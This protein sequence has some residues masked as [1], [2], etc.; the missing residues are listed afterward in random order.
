MYRRDLNQRK[1]S[2][3]ILAGAIFAQCGIAVMPAAAAEPLRAMGRLSP[4]TGWVLA[5]NHLLWTSDA[6]HAW[7]E[8]TPPA[9][10]AREL[11]GAFFLNASN[12]W[13]L[14]SHGSGEGVELARTGNGGAEWSVA[15]F[16]LGA[17]DAAGFGGEASLDF[18]DEA[19][20]WAML[21]LTSSSNFSLGMLF[22]TDDGG[23]T[24]KRLPAPPLGDP[25]RFVSQSEGWLSSSSGSN[26][27]YVTRDGGRT[28][29]R[30]SA[31]PE[32]RRAAPPG[33]R[34]ALGEN[35][36]M[37]RADF[38]DATHGWVIAT[39]AHC[40]GFKTGCTQTQKLLSTTDGGRTFQD[41]TPALAV[42]V[43]PAST[44]TGK[45][46]GF[47]QCA[48]GSTSQMDT[49]YKDSPFKSSNV[50]I[51]GADRGCSQPGLNSSW[52]STVTGQG[53]KLIPT[54]V[55]PQAP[56]NTSCPTC[57]QF[58]SNPSTA[59]SQ[60]TSEAKSA[61]SA[62]A[63][64]G[65][66]DTIVYYDLEI[67]PTGNSSCSAAVQA[68]VNAW[69]SEMHSEGNLAG[70]YGSPANAKDDW[71]PIN[72]SPDDVWIALWNHKATVRNLPPLSN[73]DWRGHRLHQYR[74]AHRETY[75][76]VEFSIDSD[77][78]DGAVTP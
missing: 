60:G 48:V 7:T 42:G 74:G 67:Y 35:A 28:W 57:S 73:S 14:R 27:S 9:S 47:D 52:V 33:V 24:W 77:Y 55:G 20:G 61:S 5:G 46:Q 54:W 63:G 19:H 68:F 13:L 1:L 26:Q 38:A 17:D 18:I 53:W 50:Y 6:G 21:R 43:I 75:G 62:A 71:L 11:Y 76:G 66:K 64:L 25:V 70:V 36:A 51:G 58:S 37:S 34:Q 22:A 56:C 41:V 31:A 65:L 12:G 15:A 8:I 3:L 2:K 16:A 69:V 49:W 32:L 45:G 44:S 23:A 29:Q 72:H 40:T 4:Q 59:A 30:T 78:L 10:P 39:Y